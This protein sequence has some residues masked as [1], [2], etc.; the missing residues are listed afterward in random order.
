MSDGISWPFC[1]EQEF[2][3][4]S[5][6][7][8]MSMLFTIKN[9]YFFFFLYFHYLYSIYLIIQEYYQHK[10]LGEIAYPSAFAAIIYNEWDGTSGII[11]TAKIQKIL[12]HKGNYNDCTLT[13]TWLFLFISVLHLPTSIM[14]FKYISPSMCLCM[15]IF[16][17]YFPA[18]IK[19]FIPRWI[20]K[21][22]FFPD[23]KRL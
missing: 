23:Y 1:S 22:N 10:W 8:L 7:S 2:E 9:L 3:P 5:S 17:F 4:G 6:F 16:T 18:F 14:V 20:G 19:K 11:S 12:H 15:C 13:I 21:D